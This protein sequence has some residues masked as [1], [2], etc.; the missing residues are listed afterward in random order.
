MLIIP[1][2]ARFPKSQADGGKITLPKMLV[3]TAQILSF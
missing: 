2:H 3:S 1:A